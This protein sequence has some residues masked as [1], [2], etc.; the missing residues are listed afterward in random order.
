LQN[1]EEGVGI[2][3]ISDELLQSALR[4]SAGTS[5]AGK[6]PVQLR[7]RWWRASPT[8]WWVVISVA[9][10]FVAARLLLPLGVERYVNRQLNRARDY[11]GRIGNV[12]IQLWRGRYRIDNIGIFKRSGVVHVPLFAADHLYLSMEWK[13]LFHGSLVGQ[14]RME[15]PRLNFVAGPTAEQTQTGKGEDWQEMLESLFP[16]KLNK[17]EID[18]GQIH[19]Q[20]E[21]SN[22]HVDIFLNNCFAV[23]TNLTNSRE[24]RSGLPAG[25]IARGTSVGGGGLDVQLQLD[26]LAAAPTYQ[27]TAKLTNVDLPAMNDFLKAYG[28]FDVESGSFS[29][30]ASA[31]SK[32]GNYDGYAKV[33]F[34]NLHVFAWKKE[35]KKNALEVFWQAIVGTLTTAFK[36]QPRDYLATRIPFSGSYGK[37]KIGTWMAVGSMLRNAFIKA[38]VPKM[39][40]PVTLDKVEKKEEKEGK[41]NDS[42]PPEKGGQALARPP[43]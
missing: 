41:M 6:S 35:R 39:D 13:E 31:A 25:V 15:Y 32:E 10:V 2:D 42:P 9:F 26:P 5:L 36:N 24:I 1:A 38:L 12:H 40:E 8:T 18:H 28:K 4:P 43:P 7:E 37:E 27:V 29:L 23:A 33:F 30:F 17:V 21:Y 34:G 19:F 14:I 11:G 22:P 20:N 16:F 3:R